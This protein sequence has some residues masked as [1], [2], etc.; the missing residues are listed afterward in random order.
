MKNDFV[1]TGEL[2]LA[3]ETKSQTKRRRKLDTKAHHPISPEMRAAI[4]DAVKRLYVD[5]NVEAFSIPEFCARYGVSRSTAYE[6]IDAGLLIA[7]K[8]EGT[9]RTL[10]RRADA[11]AWLATAPTMKARNS[12]RAAVHS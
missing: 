6:Q 5:P 8:P 10:I 12:V 3:E 9:R 2:D 1:A 7:K 4:D 11:D